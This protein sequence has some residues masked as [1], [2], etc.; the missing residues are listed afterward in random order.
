MRGTGFNCGKLPGHAEV[1]A[2]VFHN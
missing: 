1:K 2:G